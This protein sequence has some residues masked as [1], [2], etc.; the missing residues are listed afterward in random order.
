[1]KENSSFSRGPPKPNPVIVKMSDLPAFMERRLLEHHEANISFLKIIETSEFDD[2]RE[3]ALESAYRGITNRIIEV[4]RP[5]LKYLLADKSRS[6]II[7]ALKY[8]DKE[9]LDALDKYKKTGELADQ[10]IW[11]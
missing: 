11:R 6:G 3:F 2:I 7:K 10:K 9:V 4:D 8:L 1:M 5:E